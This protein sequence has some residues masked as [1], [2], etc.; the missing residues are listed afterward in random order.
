MG[1]GFVVVFWL[2]AG[3]IFAIVGGSLMGRLTAWLL[4]ATGPNSSRVVTMARRF[5]FA[6]FAWAAI[7]FVVQGAVNTSL[8][9]RD[10]GLG[11]DWYAPLPNHYEIVLVD[12]TDQ[13]LVRQQ[14][15]NGGIFGVRLLQVAGPYL[16]GGSDTQSFAH[17]GTDSSTVDSYF[18]LNTGNGAMTVEPNLDALTQAA[19][20]A[21][22]A[23][24]LEPIDS[25]YE[26]YRFMWFDILAGCLL[27]LPPLAVFLMLGWRILRLRK[28][29]SFQTS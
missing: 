11:D 16:L 27:V 21:G 6:C 20:R 5:P 28:V 24:R 15:G 25:V 13:G 19:S 1:I 2:V 8:L 14:G 10:V 17:S 18:M 22:I 12:V 3:T 4:P 23:L 9:H 7:V 26:R 29:G